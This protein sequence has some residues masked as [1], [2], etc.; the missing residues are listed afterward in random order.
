MNNVIRLTFMLL[1]VPMLAS[2]QWQFAGV[3]P[4]STTYNNSHGMVVDNDGK[5]WNGP[6]YSELVNE[7]TE[8]RSQIYIFNADGTQASF[9]P[10]Y[11]VMV[12]DTMFRF[13]SVT[14]MSKS[15]TGTIYVAMHGHRQTAPLLSTGTPNAVTGGNWNTS[16]AYVLELNAS[17]G[18]LINIANVTSIRVAA[19]P[20]ALEVSHAPNRAAVTADGFVVISYVFGGSQIAIYDPADNWSVVQVVTNDKRGFSRSLEVSADGTMIFNP[21]DAPLAE[22]R[23]T[24]HIQVL[25][26]DDIF[27]E[28]AVAAPIAEGT[29]AGAIARYPG[30]AG[31]LYFS[32]AG[33]GNDPVA[34][35]GFLSSSYY[36]MSLNSGLKVD[37]FA[38]NFGTATAYR[39]PRA[40]AFSDDGL[41]AYV[42]SFNSGLLNIQKFTRTQPVSVDRGADMATGFELSQNYPNPFNPTTTISYTLADAGLT[43]LRV[44][45]MLGRVVSTLVNQ[46][47]PAGTHR[48]NFDASNLGSGVYMYELTSGSVRL[49]N[50]MTLVK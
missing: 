10:M 19:T 8:R 12:A 49:T 45:D 21:N 22:G 5:L 2:A 23:P 43:T 25:K 47:M 40:M 32:G 1:L 34:S 4:D 44:Y 26:S 48:V 9:S 15:P 17:T 35:N 36:G 18:E 33:V 24:G 39:I 41:T 42:G 27:S 6:Y 14:G 38:W 30:D 11:N 29:P 16:K 37:E 28:F 46:D 13:G 50:K 20:T 3:F 31:I 7:G